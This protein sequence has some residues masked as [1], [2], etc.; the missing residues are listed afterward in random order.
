MITRWDPYREMISMRRAMDRL[1]DSSLGDEL[2]AS[3]PQWALALDVLEDEDGYQVKAT[4]PGVKPEDIDV[5]YDK[6]SLTIRGEI[7]DDSE[8]VKGQYQLRERRFGVFSR[9]ISLPTTIKA[10]AIEAS[11]QDGILT[12]RLPKE[13][14]VKP[15]RIAVNTSG[16]K[17]V[18]AKSN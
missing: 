17:I 8:T 13:E 16:Q 5:T 6:G 15:R 7:K 12:L 18:N 11:Y 1:I 14:E 3:V 9:T 4:V 10:E 2:P